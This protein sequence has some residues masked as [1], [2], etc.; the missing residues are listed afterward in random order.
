MLPF[1]AG[2]FTK[3]AVGKAILGTVGAAAVG[4]VQRKQAKKDLAEQRAY[5]EGAMQR[6]RDA[7]SNAGFNPLTALRAGALSSFNT[8]GRILPTGGA[9][10][11]A[12]YLGDAIGEAF[13][14]KANEPIEKYNAEI[15]RLEILQR[16]ADLS[17]S[18]ATLGQLK[19]PKALT[20]PEMPGKISNQYSQITVSKLPPRTSETAF[21]QSPP[22][23]G[24]NIV[25]P[26]PTPSADA[27]EQQYGEPVSWAYGVSKLVADMYATGILAGE[28]WAKQHGKVYGFN[29]PARGKLV[30]E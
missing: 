27:M 8:P 9:A 26:A 28:R 30:R 23:L 11:A 19:T 12:Q 10:F 16:E 6:M 17:I 2:M 22:F 29:N 4:A 7:A 14:K 1:L 20:G 3:A 13:D 25:T 15:R 24:P 21:Q 18:R 5:D